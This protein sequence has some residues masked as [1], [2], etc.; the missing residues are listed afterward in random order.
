MML[1]FELLNGLLQFDSDY[2]VVG[3][4]DEVTLRVSLVLISDASEMLGFFDPMMNI[5]LR[6]LEIECFFWFGMVIWNGFVRLL[7]WWKGWRLGLQQALG[8]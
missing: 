2:L 5:V 7:G 3:P 1:C 6:A 8:F 4:C